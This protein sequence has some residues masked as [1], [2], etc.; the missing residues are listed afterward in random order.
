MIL[1]PIDATAVFSASLAGTAQADV[2]QKRALSRGLDLFA[3]KNYDQAIKQL[4][5]AIGYA[6][7]TDNAIAAYQ[8]IAQS[9]TNLNDSEGAINAYKQALRVDNRRSDVHVALGNI[10]YFQKNY[11][12]AIASYEAAVNND[13]GEANRYSL[14]QGYLADKQFDKAE[15][16]FD[17][18]SQLSPGSPSGKYGLGLVYEKRGQYEAALGY[19]NEAL[20][21]K[22]DFYEAYSEMGYVLVDSGRLD[23][24]AQIRDELAELNPTLSIQL[25]QYINSK[26]PPKMILAASSDFQLT[27]GPN[28]P[29]VALNAYL[30]NPNESQLFSVSF[31]FSKPMDSE[32]VTNV[33]NWKLGRSSGLAGMTAYNYGMPISE[34]EASLSPHPVSVSYDEKYQIAT[35]FFALTQNASGDATIDPGHIQFAFSGKD[36]DGLLMHTKADQYGG[37]SGFA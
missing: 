12:E 15:L 10:Y 19:F 28:T 35:V 8:F 4:K 5:S 36:L 6:P 9:F 14:G 26:S 13:P 7:T 27:M 21:I 33:V 16:E 1:D 2:L 22:S 20:S 24:A 23:E 17:R 11:K 30:A 32:T 37:F 3:E 25:S 34:K 18:V 31:S 29:L